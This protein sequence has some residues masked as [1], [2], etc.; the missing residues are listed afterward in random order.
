MYG[1]WDLWDLLGSSEQMRLIWRHA[2][3]I[4]FVSY[5]YVQMPDRK[6]LKGG[7]AY[8]S[9]QFEGM[10]PVMEGKA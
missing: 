9:S 10:H 4:S 7:R 8:S 5:H 1:L 6:L 2:C 3:Y